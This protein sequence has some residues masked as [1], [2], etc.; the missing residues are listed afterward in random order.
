MPRKKHRI[1][2]AQKSFRK[3]FKR[4]I[5]FAIIAATGFLIAFSWRN[6]VYNSSRDLVDKFTDVADVVLSEIYTAVFITL[7]GVLL[8]ILSSRILREK[9]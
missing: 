2:N 3:E 4:Q 6:A 7:M 9:R 5:R 8:I 1:F